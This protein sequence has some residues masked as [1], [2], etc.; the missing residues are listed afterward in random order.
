MQNRRPRPRMLLGHGPRPDA[1]P[2]LAREVSPPLPTASN[3]YSE[4]DTLNMRRRVTLCD[5]GPVR[6][7]GGSIY[8]KCG[9]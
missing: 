4:W 5:P 3:H 2:Y 9:G 6:R 1:T 8:I 7:E